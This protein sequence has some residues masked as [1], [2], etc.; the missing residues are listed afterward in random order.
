MYREALEEYLA[1]LPEVAQKETIEN[2]VEEQK[3]PERVE[4]HINRKKVLFY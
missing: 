2:I 4:G 1:S 3:I